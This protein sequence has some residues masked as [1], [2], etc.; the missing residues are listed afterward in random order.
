MLNVVC[1]QGRFTQDPELRSTQNGEGVTSFTLAVRRNYGKDTDFI[2]CT[3]WRDRAVDI[4]A[5]FK[6][7]SQ[8]V[9]TGQ[10]QVRAYKDKNGNNRKATEVVV[11][12]FNFVDKKQ[13]EP[14]EPMVVVENDE[15]LPF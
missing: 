6:K 12:R 7:G 11:D 8:I 15:D 2:D 5:Y 9:V 10:L 4:C 3:A 14:V 13:E 1:L